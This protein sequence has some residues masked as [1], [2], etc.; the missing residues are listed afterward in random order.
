MTTT[1]SLTLARTFLGKNVSLVFDRPIGTKHPKYGY[2]YTVNYGYVPGVKA[3]DGGDLDA[4]YLGTNQPLIKAEGVCIAI[5][6]R[7]DDDDDKLI[8]VP[9]ETLLSDAEI[10]ATIDFQEQ[11]FDSVILR[12]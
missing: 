11:W 3:P 2:V 12:S 4:Y 8:V 9:R 1:A 5:V 10:R 6:H 7:R